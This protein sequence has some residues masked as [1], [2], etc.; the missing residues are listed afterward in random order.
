MSRHSGISWCDCSFTPWFGCANVSAACDHCY[1]EVW[2][3][4]FRKAI[5]GPHG[6]RPRSAASTWRQP[7]AWNR[8][9]ARDGKRLTV[10]ISE[11]SDVFDNKAAE[12]DR[13]DLWQ[14]MRDTP[15][16]L[17]I[18]LTKRPQNMAKMLPADWPLANVWLGVTAEN[19]VEAQRRMPILAA[20]PAAGRFVSCE[21]LLG[22]VDLT[23]WLD[24]VDFVIAGC[25]SRGA[26][27]GRP[28]E[29]AWVRSLRDQCVAADVQFHLKQ[30]GGADGRIVHLPELEGQRWADK[31]QPGWKAEKRRKSA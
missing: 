21:P 6:T 14:L 4:R 19:E 10:F 25:E 17:W 30:L 29:I 16:L 20:T 13:A 1:A 9:A 18:V 22:P 11:N 3:H 26:R 27:T 23:P 15:H 28:T 24:R 8:K 2:T 7:L 5:W 12:A 31:P